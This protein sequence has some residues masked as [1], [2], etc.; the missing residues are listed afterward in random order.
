M[1][2]GPRMLLAPGLEPGLLKASATVQDPDVRLS[3]WDAQMPVLAIEEGGVVI[4]LEFADRDGFLRFQRRV[5]AL[6]VRPLHSPPEGGSPTPGRDD[7]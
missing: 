4:E 6:A 2:V 5:A 1:T 7:P 3:C